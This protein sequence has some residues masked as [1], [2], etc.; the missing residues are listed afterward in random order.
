MKL[1]ELL[2]N[3]SL[4]MIHNSQTKNEF[5]KRIPE[6]KYNELKKTSAQFQFAEQHIASCEVKGSC[7][8]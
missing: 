2:E 4:K 5:R 1:M 8:L 6:I 7:N 3:S